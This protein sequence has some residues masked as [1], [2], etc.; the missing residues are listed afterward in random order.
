[1]TDD[2]EFPQK[3]H[4]GKAGRKPGYRKSGRKTA[5][6]QFRA[7]EDLNQRLNEYRA[8][9]LPDCSNQALLEHLIRKALDL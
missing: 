7:D 8:Q 2:L 5:L 1:M 9:N 4:K 6:W 3:S